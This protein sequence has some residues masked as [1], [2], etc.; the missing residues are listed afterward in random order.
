MLSL[1]VPEVYNQVYNVYI[2]VLPNTSKHPN[3]CNGYH[4]VWEM[5][6]YQSILTSL[7]VSPRQTYFFSA[8]LWWIY[9]N[10]CH[11]RRLQSNSKIKLQEP[12][13]LV[14]SNAILLLCYPVQYILLLEH[15]N[16]FNPAMTLLQWNW[17]NMEIIVQ[18]P[19]IYK[20]NLLQWSRSGAISWETVCLMQHLSLHAV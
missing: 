18:I 6:P 7:S 11:G 5:D 13:Q 12:D 2:S 20:G 8:T 1:D 16:C 9:L 4:N 15:G 10:Y 19:D 3:I 14:S 17:E